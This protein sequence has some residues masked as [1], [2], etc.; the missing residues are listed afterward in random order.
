MMPSILGGPTAAFRLKFFTGR[1]AR[2]SK[3]RQDTETWFD[4]LDLDDHV[5]F[6]GK[7]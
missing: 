3:T 4:Y 1:V 6:A 7:A 2:C 5:T